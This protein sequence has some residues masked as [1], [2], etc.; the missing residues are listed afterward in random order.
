MLPLKKQVPFKIMFLSLSVWLFL[1]QPLYF[2]ACLLSYMCF[3][4]A[5]HTSVIESLSKIV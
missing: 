4:R 1:D 5:L 2:D 3:L